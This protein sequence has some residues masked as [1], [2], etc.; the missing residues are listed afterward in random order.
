MLSSW[1]PPWSLFRLEA[2][3]RG[4]LVFLEASAE[5]IVHAR[6]AGVPASQSISTDRFSRDS[7]WGVGAR[8]GQGNWAVEA[9]YDA[10]ANLELRSIPNAFSAEV[11]VLLSPTGSGVS[12]AASRADLFSG[13][14][15]RTFHP[16]NG[17][18][19]L[20]AGVGAGRF[21]A[22]D[23]YRNP[24]LEQIARDLDELPMGVS[25]PEVELAED[26]SAMAFVGSLGIGL[27]FGRILVRPR[28]DAVLARSLTTDLNV[29]WDPIPGI[30][31]GPL[32]LGHRT[33]V[34]P[35]LLKLSVDMGISN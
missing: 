13:Q 32:S 3:G 10:F 20:S 26:S 9:T 18:I 29:T 5:D 15:V 19:E 4:T 25:R 14:L 1:S 30:G 21:R 23:D 12:F 8:V 31:F 16:R 11:D 27:R 17:R 33:S 22:R 2:F 28:V 34:R 7:G 35:A 6:F 24:L